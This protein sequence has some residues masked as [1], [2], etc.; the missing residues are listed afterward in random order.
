M[1]DSI[2]VARR[3]NGS[4][5][6]RLTPEMERMDALARQA[7]AMASASI[8]PKEYQGNPGNCLL[9]IDVAQRTGVP[10][11][12]VTQNLY[13]IQGRPTW[14]SKFLIGA[15]NHCGRFTPLRFVME[16]EESQPGWRCRAVATAKVDGEML[17]GPWITWEMA[18]NEGW[19]SKSGS[20]WKTMPDLMIRYRAAAF[21][22]R[23]YAPDISLG[24]MTAEEVRDIGP[25]NETRKAGLMAALDDVVEDEAEVVEPEP[26]RVGPDGELF[27]ED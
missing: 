11:L 27:P 24:L 9:A 17:E 2:T 8:V 22:A 19:V 7:Q 20:K 14:S 3:S 13:I 26:A 23:V 18:Q 25:D 16:G 5:L 6:A 21:W 12:T 1:S 10:V 4:G 15:V